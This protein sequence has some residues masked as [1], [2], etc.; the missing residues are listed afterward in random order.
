MQL[1]PNPVF[2]ALDEYHIMEKMARTGEVGWR[3]I[4][5]KS[6]K[7]TSVRGTTKAAQTSYEEHRVSGAQLHF[8]ADDQ[9]EE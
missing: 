6:N 2:R 3:G 4:G 1:E 9:T 7:V 5:N 8:E